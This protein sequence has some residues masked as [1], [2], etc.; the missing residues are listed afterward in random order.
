MVGS[1]AVQSPIL[2]TT[3]TGPAYLVAKNGTSVSHPGESKTE[4]EEAAFPDVVLVPQGQGVRKPDDGRNQS[5]MARPVLN[6]PKSVD[7][8]EVGASLV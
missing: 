2:S 5:P 8:C 6:C 1:A 4:K 7:F 3:M